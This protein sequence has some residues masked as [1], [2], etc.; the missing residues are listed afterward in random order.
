MNITATVPGRPRVGLTVP[1]RGV[2]SVDEDPTTL[3]AVGTNGDV[4]I[5]EAWLPT[6]ENKR[7]EALSELQIEARIYWA[8]NLYWVGQRVGIPTHLGEFA[9]INAIITD[10]AGSKL[11]L[12]TISD[13][14]GGGRHGGGMSISPRELQGRSSS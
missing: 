7:A 6:D 1:I 9:T 5:L 4:F 2:A 12:V 8:A 13:I 3:L 10:V 11:V 14:N